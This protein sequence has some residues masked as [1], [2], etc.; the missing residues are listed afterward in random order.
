MERTPHDRGLRDAMRSLILLVLA[1]SMLVSAV[2]CRTTSYWS[3]AITG[4]AFEEKIFHSSSGGHILLLPV[5]VILVA[6]DILFLP[7]AIPH[8][9]W[10]HV[11][12]G[13]AGPEAP[14]GQGGE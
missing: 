12:R 2:G 7:V 14:T 5:L 13:R 10:L 8:D 1:V 4:G 6:L 11:H 9:I 3:F